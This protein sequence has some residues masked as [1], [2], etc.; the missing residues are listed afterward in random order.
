MAKVLLS[1]AESRSV[2]R[3]WIERRW[4][5]L[6]VGFAIALLAWGTWEGFRTAPYYVSDDSAL[7]QHAGWYITQGA[8]PYV[9]FWDLKPPLIY[10]VTTVLALLA[11]GDMRLLHLLSV[12]VAIA[13]VIAGVALV[14]LLTYRVTEDG[15]AGLVAGV[16][17]FA[18]PS[19]YT[20]PFAGIRP[21]YFAFALGAAALLLAVSDRPAWSGAAGATAA[22][23]WQL[24]AP[25]ALL[26]VAM[27]YQRG[28]R[29]AA[30]RTVLGG[31]LVA[32]GVV[33]PFVAAGL[34]VPL[35]LETVL[36]S[37]YGV[38]NYS[39]AGRLLGVVV[40]LGYGA[41]LLPLGAYG[42]A[43]AIVDDPERYW[44]VGAGGV[45]YA[46]QIFLEFQGAIELVLLVLFLAVGVGLLV[47]R[48]RT[49]SREAVVAGVVALIVAA[50]LVWAVAPVTSARDS[51][52]ELQESQ[53]VSSYETLPPE[54]DGAPSMQTIYWERRQ[55]DICHYRL[56]HKQRWYA[57]K[58]GEPL[59]KPKC[60]QWPYDDPPAE[61]AVDGMLPG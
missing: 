38:E 55:P 32:A 7:F 44:W 52:T 31:V 46:L 15:F 39:V 13:T 25:I 24:G 47:A 19:L 48:A 61:W 49:P 42:W 5:G 33:L 60:G 22:G 3:G 17:T 35:F 9:D 10:G 12:A 27:G 57:H 30:G 50:S 54:P 1:M 45:V 37:V 14:G 40:E 58:M 29:R 28:G 21:K 59:D 6:L 51:V 23:F 36:G 56:G 8:T 34:A 26:V 20:Y 53:T 41:L 4:L 11:G 2:W 43:R 16:A 18:L